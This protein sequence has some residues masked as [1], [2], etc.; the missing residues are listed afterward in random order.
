MNASPSIAIVGGSLVGP[1]LALMLNHAGF[2]DVNVYEA[3][4]ANVSQ[5]GGVIGID[6]N[7]L[8]VLDGLGIEQS[9][10]VPFPSERIL[11]IKYATDGGRVMEQAFFS[12]RT[13]A[14]NQLHANLVT[15]LPGDMLHL[16]RRVTACHPG[17]NG[18]AVLEFTDGT[19]TTVNIV[20]F[21]DG[22][23]SVG[24]KTLQPDRH[25]H[26][27]GYTAT[28]GRTICTD[29]E[30]CDFVRYLPALKTSG[31][32]YEI[33]PIILPDGRMGVDWVLMTN[34]DEDTFHEFYGGTPTTHTFVLPH[35]ISSAARKY[36]DRFAERMLPA[37]MAAL[38]HS[39]VERYVVPIVDIIPPTSAVEYI[40]EAPAVIIGDALAPV[41]PNTATGLT[42]G[43][44]Q[45]NGLT[46]GLRQHVV[47]GANLQNVLT[48]FQNRYLP[49]VHR[50]LELGPKRAAEIGLG[51]TM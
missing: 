48:G 14:W 33:F 9:A 30:L 1:A 43:L 10:V 2:E 6:Y 35:K 19:T 13:T 34:A 46:Q 31:L 20:V 49:A 7:S 23:Q 32:L 3:T 51:V 37:D 47:H 5:V 38:V 22:R 12:G 16:G 17:T 45:A 29:E 18:T 11:T 26:Y 28:R 27:S 21:A 25:L 40:G 39:T 24:R 36:I 4:D 41:H 15:A 44:D 50:A 42:S 8:N